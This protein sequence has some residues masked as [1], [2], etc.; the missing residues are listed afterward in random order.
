MNADT[1]LPSGSGNACSLLNWI[2][3]SWICGCLE[4]ELIGRDILNDGVLINPVKNSLPFIVIDISVELGLF[5][6][7]SGKNPDISNL[8]DLVFDLKLK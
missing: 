5:T 7:L 8:F 2:F 4:N 1:N 3:T 6:K